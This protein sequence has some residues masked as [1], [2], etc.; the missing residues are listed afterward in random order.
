MNSQLN[1]STLSAIDFELLR[2][3]HEDL[4][5]RAETYPAEVEAL[6]H[7]HHRHLHDRPALAAVVALRSLLRIEM[8]KHRGLPH[9]RPQ[10]INGRNLNTLPNFTQYQMFALANRTCNSC[11][12][13]TLGPLFHLTELC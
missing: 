6:V 12:R 3:T 2:G 4:R 8:N 1:P 9:T 7:A 10:S 11:I 5:Y 13:S